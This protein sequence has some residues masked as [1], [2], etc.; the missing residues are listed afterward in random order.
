MAAAIDI[1][2]ARM[3][4]EEKVV[5]SRAAFRWADETAMITLG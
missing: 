2:G 3:K 1:D 4:E 5:T